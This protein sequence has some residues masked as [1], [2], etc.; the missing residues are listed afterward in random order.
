MYIA[1]A[2]WLLLSLGLSMRREKKKHAVLMCAGILTDLLLVLH[3]QL[4]RNAIEVATSLTLGFGSSY[5]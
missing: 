1:L 5:T 4:T 2:A 3:L